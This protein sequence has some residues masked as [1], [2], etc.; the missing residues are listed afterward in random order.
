MSISTDGGTS[1]TNFT[2]TSGLGS[3]TVRGVFASGSTVYAA[4]LSG[5]SIGSPGPLSLIWTA[6]SGTWGASGTTWTTG[7]GG[8]TVFMAGDTATFSGTAGGTLTLSGS[9]APASLAVSATA[10]TYTFSGS[11]GNLI[12][13]SGALVK[14]GAGVAVFT[15]AND[16]TGGATLSAG[17]IR[18][19]ADGALGSGS[20]ELNGGTLA[21]ANASARVLSNP[22]AFGGDV[23]I[24][25][26]TGTGAMTFS[27]GVD[28]WGGTRSLTTVA[29]TT[30]SGTLGNG[31]LTKAGAGRLTL[32]G[33]S[34]FTGPTTI[35]AGRLSVNGIL[36][37]TPVAVAAAAELGGS[38]SIGGPVS[39]AGG[40]T[41][42]PGNSI[43]SLATGTATFAAAATFAY[44]VDSTNPSSLNTAADL[45][46]VSGDLILDLGN[47][48]LL[49]FADVASSIQPFAN[50]TTVFTMINYSGTWNGGLFT[51]GGTPLADGSR[52]TV[53]SQQWEIDYNSSTGGDNFTGDYLPS[54]SFVNVMGV[55]EPSTLAIIGIGLAG[56]LLAR[57]RGRAC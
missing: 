10:G 7:S 26:G 21:S 5:F 20:L 28:L 36:G 12:S 29:D 3:N 52:F 42:A 57:R 16:W 46:V 54:S 33:T 14:S 50:F 38:G 45:L 25:D 24:G 51:Y 9:L 39:V 32:T 27:G 31:G 13:G 22:V 11:A 30:F 41:L 34:T 37:D 56:L 23:A 2:T 44:E 35:S 17:T 53:G 48:T 49:T 8:A 55:P 6:T 18:V 19:A 40:G 47:A 43:E 4:T 1:Y 15:S